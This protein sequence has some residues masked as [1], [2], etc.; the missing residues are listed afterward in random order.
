MPLHGGKDD[1]DDGADSPEGLDEDEDKADPTTSKSM[2]K[3]ASKGRMK[4]PAAAKKTKKHC[5]EDWLLC[6]EFYFLFF[7][8]PAWQ[9]EPEQRLPFQHLIEDR[10]KNSE[11]SDETAPY[12]PSLGQNVSHQLGVHMIKWNIIVYLKKR[13]TTIVRISDISYI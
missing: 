2:K 7:I 1:S 4:K 8:H 13:C 5:D 11:E 9:E 12:E 6:R 10:C 3:P